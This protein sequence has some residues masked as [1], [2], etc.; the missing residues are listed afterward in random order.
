MNAPFEQLQDCINQSEI[1]N[2]FQLVICA[3]AIQFWS[4]KVEKDTEA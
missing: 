1:R 3:N 4:V 2:V